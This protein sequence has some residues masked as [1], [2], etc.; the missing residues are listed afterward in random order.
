MTDDLVAWLRTQLD[1]DEASDW[2]HRPTCQGR[3]PMPLP[4]GHPFA[5]PM[6]CNCDAA[7]RWIA[8]IEAKRRILDLTTLDTAEDGGPLFLGGYGEAYWDVAR[9]LALP[10]ADR[11]G[12]RPEWKP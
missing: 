9:L 3:R 10:Y 4:D 2:P 5:G 8:D 1:I 12:Y 7:T 11:P 6:S